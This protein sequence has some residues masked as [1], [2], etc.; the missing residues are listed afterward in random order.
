MAEQDAPAVFESFDTLFGT[1]EED[2]EMGKWFPL[3]AKISVKVRRYSSKIS[4]KVRENLEAPFATQVKV[5]GFKIPPETMEAINNEHLATGILADWKGVK[6]T[7]GVEVPYSKAAAIQF[8]TRLPDLRN[9]VASLSLEI[10]NYRST[11]N[12]GVAGN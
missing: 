7:K 1:S 2:A 6:D 12:E 5:P 3:S 4:K 9:I 8:L 11:V 10:D